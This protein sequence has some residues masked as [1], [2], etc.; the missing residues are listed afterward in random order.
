MNFS[1]DD[2]QV[3]FQQTVSR[4]LENDSVAS[5]KA[6]RNDAGGIGRA[7][8][9]MMGELGLFSLCL[10]ES[11]GGI[12]SSHFDML[13]ISESFG[14]GGSADNWLENAFMPIAVVAACR[15][16]PENWLEHILSGE[17]IA[18]LAFAEP[19]M[20]YHPMPQSTRLEEK[21][22]QFLLSGEKTMAIAAAAAD[23]FFVTALH[24][25]KLVLCAVAKDAK[26]LDHSNYML[27]DGS[28]AAN[29]R[30]HAVPVDAGDVAEMLPE[31]Y[32]KAIGLVRLMAIA[33]MTGL[34]DRVLEQT[35]VYVRQRTQFGQAIGRFQALQH[36]LVDCYVL[37]DQNRSLLCSASIALSENSDN[38]LSEIAG[39]RAIVSENAIHI[40]Q[41]AI[42]MH[43]GMGTTDELEISHLHKR[44]LQLSRLFGDASY[45]LKHY[46]EA[47]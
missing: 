42:Q 29:I 1:Y 21:N 2:N 4:M 19:Q 12:A 35:L 44:I 30:F 11:D 40:G 39:A 31:E 23:T 3:M 38:A 43:G 34:C 16:I 13:A 9:K 14:A 28:H 45:C 18:C 20:R 17:Q 27:I 8:W 36:R 33:E 7:R 37:T 47:A 22:G 26:G 6:Q 15:K 5:R 41:E 24:N 46:R 25:E 32:H 10:S